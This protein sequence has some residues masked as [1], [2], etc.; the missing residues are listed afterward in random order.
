MFTADMKK[1]NETGRDRQAAKQQDKDGVTRRNLL[2]G[3]L[4][5]PSA[6]ALL[7]ACSRDGPRESEE[8]AQPIRIGF[9]GAVLNNPFWDQMQRG[10]AAA[11]EAL[12]GVDLTYTAPEEF[13]LANVNEMIRAVIAGGPDGIAIDYR[14]RE[15]EEITGQALDQ[16]I[17]VQFFNNFKGLDSAD[18]RIVRLS[19]TAVGLDKYE[20][21][22]KSG[23]AFLKFLKLNDPLVLFNGLPDTPEH[24]VIQNAYLRVFS[25]AGWAREQIDVFPVGLDPAQNFQ[26]IKVY[27]AAHPEIR[28]IVCWD[29]LVGSAAARAKADAGLDTPTLSW[30]L[31]PIIIQSLK[32]GSLTLTLS[33][34][35][36]LQGY[37]AVVA[38]YLKLKH[39]LSDPPSVDT[40]AFLI[41]RSNVLEVE[42][43]FQKGLLG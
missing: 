28:G 36:Y 41:D 42:K 40:G 3:G 6:G 4:T 16:G 31:D 14:G 9:I 8:N 19:R 33:Q 26:L 18:P 37:Y 27:L 34:Q 15:F 2:I 11:A 13:S 38:L 24:L 21:A 12:A 25:E 23:E 20:A 22:R 7:A 17:A 5:V 29:S 43:L 32:D 30:N 10:A 39:G 35:P 1:G